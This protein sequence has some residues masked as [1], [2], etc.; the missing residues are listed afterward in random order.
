MGAEQD[1]DAQLLPD[2]PGQG[3]DIGGVAGVQAGHRLVQQEQAGM[4]QQRL[5]QQEPLA[6]AAGQG[7]QRPVGQATGV[8]PVQ[9]I[10]HR[11]APGG[12]QPRQA[13][14]PAA[15]GAGHEVPAAQPGARGLGADLRHVAD[16]GS[17]RGRRP[18]QHADAARRRAQQAQDG[19]EQGGL[20]RAVRAE[21]ANEPARRHRER[22]VIQHPAPA[23]RQGDA[24]QLDR[25]RGHGCD[26]ARSSASNW[27]S[28][29]DT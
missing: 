8:H 15:H 1:G 10:Q 9:R 14:A 18:A 21:H 24:P 28:I 19:A 23:R 3:D 29:Q 25:G 6:L 20:P 2:L 7:L 17:A 5:G 4:V 16:A 13:P 26:S 22:H 11:R 12:P 27:P